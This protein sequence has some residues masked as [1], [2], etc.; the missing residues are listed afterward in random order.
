LMN[1][2][3]WEL[4]KSL[5]ADAADLPAADRERFVLEH[6]S[7][8]GLRREVLELLGSPAPLTN[9]I[10]ANALRPGERLGPYVIEELLGRGGMGE[11]YRAHDTTLNRAVAI[12]VLPDPFADDVERRLRLRREA[13]LLAALNHPNIA[14]IHGFEES[15]GISALVMELVDGPT[16][17]DLLGRGA[18]P[19]TDTL[20][21][22]KQIADALEAA[23]EQGIIH[24]DLKP[25]NIKVR[26]DSVVKV[27]DFG[28]AKA[29]VLTT[30]SNTDLLS[31][32]TLSVRAT[33]GGLL[34]GTAAYMPPEQALGKPV[35]KRS[36]IWAF[37][38]VLYEMLTGI[39][40]F[41]GADLSDTLSRVITKEPDWT[42]LPPNTSAPIRRLLRRCLEKD[43]NRRLADVADARLD[44]EEA[45]SRTADSSGDL[46][47]VVA[48]A[49][50][51]RRVFPWIVAAAFATALALV[52]VFGPPWRKFPVSSSPLLLSTDLGTDAALS[53]VMGTSA[54]VALSPNGRLLAFVAE[55]L[56][57][58]TPRLYV[59]HLD[60]MQAELMPGTDGATSP[61]FSPDGEWIAFFTPG[62]LNKISVSGGA[63]VTLCDAPSG[64]GGDWGDDGRIVFA[65]DLRNR[66]FGVPSS[67]GTAEP[68]TVLDG[69]EGTHR[70]PQVL[71]GGR[72]VL[73]SSATVSRT[74]FASANLVVQTLPTGTRKVVQ[75][76]AY[77]GRYLPSGHL[78]YLHGGT[79][80]AA[81]FDLGRLELT[82]PPVP[83]LEGVGTISLSGA[84]LFAVSKSG[85]FAYVAT[86]QRGGYQSP[87]DW[88]DRSGN[89]SALRSI[90]ANWGDLAFSPDGH[91]L[92]FDIIDGRQSSMWIHDVT[93]DAL[94]RLTVGPMSENSPVWTPDGRRIVFASLQGETGMNAVYNLFWRWADGTGDAQRLTT[95]EHH[96]F[97][98]SWH[99]RQKLLAFDEQGPSNVHITLLPVDGDVPSGWR[100]GKPTV[101][102]S[103]PFDVRRPAFSPDGRW[104]AYESNESG[105][106][107]VYVQRFQGQG[108]KRQIST[109]GGLFPTWSQSRHELLYSTLE[110]RIMTVTYSTDAESFQA[111]KPQPWPE[112]RYAT[113]VGFTGIRRFDL[114]PDGNRLALA[115]IRETERV[116][117]QSRVEFILNFFEELRRVS[118]GTKR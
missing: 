79:L 2:S 56:S 75:R 45:L 12:K 13:Q 35:D 61:F 91:R 103:G 101:L 117:Q 99:P 93:R 25:A 6:C 21:L 66:L 58:A 29:L 118:A 69:D 38:C 62:K 26:V 41:A 28:L 108:G 86:G 94:T 42:A 81:G 110:Q 85:T 107:E 73:Y 77:Y 54:S 109:A 51:W 114:H 104:L 97:P 16:L 96:Q 68:L 9:I 76:G 33:H 111:E 8:P 92:T 59:R 74:G 15:T 47:D 17:A 39:R 46:Q 80:F 105:Q 1:R 27:L 48:V 31:S 20:R 22:A 40:A 3:F 89:R 64:R 102:L 87:I 44:I 36:D 14:H 78:V 71:P 53:T 90:S 34:L 32:P 65:P 10:A 83:A 72:A 55:K 112:A 60:Q 37:G 116:T 67:G 50:L 30:T 82:G 11:V 43:R 113:V 19:L 95:S 57:D 70:W 88:V 23:H 18:I 5:L 115:P 106:F 63:P 98:R 100:L 4:A 7:D 24:R 49:S 52:L 84:G